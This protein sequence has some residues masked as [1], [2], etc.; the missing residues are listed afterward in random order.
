LL[1]GDTGSRRRRP[2]LYLDLVAGLTLAMGR[3]RGD[4]E[5]LRA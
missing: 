1:L 4:V 2:G 3:R 5:C